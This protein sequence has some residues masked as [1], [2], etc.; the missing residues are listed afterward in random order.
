MKKISIRDFRN[1][2]CRIYKG[3]ESYIVTKR[4]TTVGVYNPSDTIKLICERNKFSPTE[5]CKNDA[6]YF[7]RASKDDYDAQ[8]NLCV[9]CYKRIKMQAAIDSDL[10][11]EERML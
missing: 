7:I 4:G 3:R 6:S 11:I 1:N 2:F 8:G 5:K 10:E 9:A